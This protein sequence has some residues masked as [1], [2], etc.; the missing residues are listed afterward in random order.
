MTLARRLWAAAIRGIIKILT[1]MK[2]KVSRK[3]LR[4][5]F[6]AIFLLG[7]LIILDA[8]I[9]IFMS[10]YHKQGWNSDTDTART[11]PM[12]WNSWNKF[13]CKHLDE[14]VVKK[15]ADLLVSTGL[16]ASGYVYVNLDDC[17]Q[18]YRDNRGYIQPDPEKFKGGM[19]TL[20]K[21][22]HSKGLKYGLY[23]DSGTLTC[24]R[25]PGSY[26]HEIQDA[27]SYA[28]WGVD[29][30]KN[31]DCW[32]YP[33]TTSN[34]NY[35][36]MHTALSNT[37]RQII[38]S[39]KGSIDIRKS[40]HVSN[41]RRVHSDIYD[42]WEIMLFCVDS[43]INEGLERYSAPGFWNDLD[44]L[45]IGNGGMSA[46][47][48]R[49][50]MSLW[51]A[52]KSPLLLGHDL[53][54]MT[55]DE[56]EIL[57]N[58]EVIA[59]NQ[60]PLGVSASLVKNIRPADGV[61]RVIL[62]GEDCTNTE[63]TE[64]FAFRYDTSTNQIIKI[65]TDEPDPQCIEVEGDDSL[66]LRQCDKESQ[67]QKWIVK[68]NTKATKISKLTDKTKCI[69][70]ST[71]NRVSARI[72]DCK[73]H[74]KRWKNNEAW[75]PHNDEFQII[76]DLTKSFRFSNTNHMCL[77]ISSPPDINVYYGPL[78][79]GGHVVV[80]VNRDNKPRQIELKFDYLGVDIDQEYVVR[81]LW[82]RKDLGVYS[83]GLSFD[84]SNHDCVML[85]LR[86]LT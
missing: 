16:A 23:T 42:E 67:N 50:H 76:G 36:A 33:G 5:I 79:N 57:S 40:R 51:C 7:F 74:K 41:V 80:I 45:E 53:S 6:M 63:M 69:A 20:G 15:T 21:Y 70:T 60:D 58:P 9:E 68:N 1:S 46:S 56:L 81:N 34:E 52:L 82:T 37:N 25:R 86:L 55:Q 38:H 75:H 19:K 47:E 84:V 32:L 49:V 3:M 10:H 17:W 30:L 27:E 13:G 29:Y 2:T 44:M 62:T 64:S 73:A 59:I 22:I 72:Q 11:P 39:I 26:R 54:K 85:T 65:K 43:L 35:A 83:K 61:S 48:Y 14:D 18:L 66:V 77:G 4:Y 12:G 24:Q 78:H 31:D 71:Y 28:S 8:I